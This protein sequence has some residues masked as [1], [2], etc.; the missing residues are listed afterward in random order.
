[1][2]YP[3]GGGAPWLR[4]GVR[5]LLAAIALVPAQAYALPAKTAVANTEVAVLSQG[6]IVKTGDMDFGTILPPNVAGT[7]IMTPQAAPTCTPSASLVHTGGCHTAEFSILYK[8]NK[9]VF[10]RDGNNNGTITLTGPSGATMQVTNLTM[11]VTG[12]TGKA[13][14]G[15]WDFGKWQVSDTNGFA[16]LFLGGTLHVAAGQTPGTYNGTLTIEVQMN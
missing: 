1:M 6:S 12:L 7:V 2:P 11:G 4:A 13:S 10:I 15:G 9:H 14:Q 5:A 16:Q 3:A 8:N